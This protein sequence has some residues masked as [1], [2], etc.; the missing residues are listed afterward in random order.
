M[1]FVIKPEEP[2]K[3]TIMNNTTSK[4]NLSL[5][6]KDQ[7]M[8]DHIELPKGGKLTVEIPLEVKTDSGWEV[9]GIE[10]NMGLMKIHIGKKSK[11]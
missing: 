1:S 8:I 11:S 2:L 4:T 9:N 7:P 3:F 10:L 6:V 5:F